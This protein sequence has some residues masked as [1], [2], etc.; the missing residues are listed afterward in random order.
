MNERA[1]HRSAQG[2]RTRSSDLTI[3]DLIEPIVREIVNESRLASLMISQR[4]VEEVLGISARMHLEYCRRADFTP[5]V[6]RA[7]KLR[8]VD[9]SE[10]RAWLLAQDC[11]DMPHREPACDDGASHVLA[12]LGLRERAPTEKKSDRRRGTRDPR[13]SKV[14]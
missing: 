5:R 13:V 11:A 7:G 6:V 14:G 2:P 1:S 4:N 10:Y 9:A 3:R 8:L 12:E